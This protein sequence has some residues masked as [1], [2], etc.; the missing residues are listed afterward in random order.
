MTILQVVFIMA[1]CGS[2][3]RANETFQELR[4]AV[5]FVGKSKILTFSVFDQQTYLSL[6][7][8]GDHS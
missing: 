6:S 4:K 3:R 8:G 2:C 7:F 1:D 5:T